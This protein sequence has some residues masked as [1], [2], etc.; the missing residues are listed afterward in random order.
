MSRIKLLLDIIGDIRSLG[1]SLQTYAEALMASDKLDINDYEE[2][3]TPPELEEK[4]A[5]QPEKEQP[6]EPQ[7]T[8]VTLDDVRKMLAEKSRM[9]YKAEV[10][11]LVKKHGADKVSEL[12]EGTYA[13]VLKE[14]EQIGS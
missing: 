6:A 7:K 14:A 5:E 3:Y 12:P 8:E 2:I 10:K 4:S 1:D 9:G 11:A 13:G